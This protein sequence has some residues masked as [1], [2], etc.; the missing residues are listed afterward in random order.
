MTRKRTEGGD[1]SNRGGASVSRRAFLA[2]GAVAA[3]AVAGCLGGN[4]STTAVTYRHRFVREGLDPAVNDGGVEMGLWEEEG[5]DVSFETSQGSQAAT[6]SV[7]QGNDEFGNGEIAAVLGQIQAGSPLTIIGQILAPL[8]AVVSLGKKDI[9]SWEDLDGKAVAKYPFGVVGP[10]AKGAYRETT[11]GPPSEV[12]W[13]NMQPGTEG[14][15]VLEEEVDAVVTYFP[16]IVA[17]LRHNGYEPNVLKIA[18]VYDYLGVSLYTRDEVIE[19]DPELVDSF[20]RG[21][22]RA[23]KAFVTDLDTMVAATSEEQEAFSEDIQLETLGEQYASR[24]PPEEIGREYGKGWTPRDR[25]ENTQDVL[26]ELGILDE[27][28]PVEEYYTNRF[29]EQNQELAVETAELYYEELEENH[30]VGPDY[31]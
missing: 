12:T 9:T 24:V 11:G 17:R 8:P 14:Q 28:G 27:G 7:A 25:L 31:V 10:L 1:S 16:Q 20:V 15:L 22:L 13:Q 30:D 21:W 4:E 5:L 29:I 26:T 19:D 23:H 18:D 6:T 2:S 3:T